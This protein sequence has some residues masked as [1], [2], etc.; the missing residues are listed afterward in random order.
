M[1]D[2]EEREISSSLLIS[3]L[4][5]GKESKKKARR[6]INCTFLGMN[7]DLWD[8]VCGLGSEIWKGCV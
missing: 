1:K 5:D 3:D 4:K 6:S 7:D 2:L 8:R